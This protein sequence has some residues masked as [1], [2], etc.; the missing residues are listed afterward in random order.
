M[1]LTTWEN[2]PHGKIVKPDVS[3]AKNYL[4]SQSAQTAPAQYMSKLSSQILF[5]VQWQEVVIID[6][7]HTTFLQKG[8]E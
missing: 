2:A 3:I 4:V 8:S 1:G 5:Y 6:T 7:N